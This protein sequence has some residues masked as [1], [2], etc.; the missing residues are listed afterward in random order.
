MIVLDRNYQERNVR[1]YERTIV[2]QERRP[3]L[4]TKVRSGSDSNLHLSTI[5]TNSKGAPIQ[6]IYCR[7]PGGFISDK[8]NVKLDWRGVR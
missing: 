4:G 7:E 6:Y 5:V 2:L 3:A 8:L 1:S